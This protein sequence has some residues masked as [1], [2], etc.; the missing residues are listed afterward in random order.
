[1]N[2]PWFHGVNWQDILDRR[3][4]PPFKPKLASDD[5]DRYIDKSF[6][7]QELACSP[8]SCAKSPSLNGGN[9]DGWTYDAKFESRLKDSDM[10][11]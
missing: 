6:T 3:I 10:Q 11:Q 7:K 9:W 1:M 4:K 8:D 5:D 2:H